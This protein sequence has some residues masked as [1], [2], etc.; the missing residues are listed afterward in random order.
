MF[1]AVVLHGL[2]DER[3]GEPAGMDLR[4]VSNFQPAS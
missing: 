4:S 1:I 3:D 2:E